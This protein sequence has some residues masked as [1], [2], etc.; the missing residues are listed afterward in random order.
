MPMRPTTGNT[1][2]RTIAVLVLVAIVSATPGLVLAQDMHT[3]TGFITDPTG[4]PSAG[5]QVVLVDSKTAQEFKSPPTD[6]TGLYSLAVP[7]GT[8]YTIVRVEAPDGTAMSVQELPPA[9]ALTAGVTTLSVRFRQR[10]DSPAAAPP[11]AGAAAPTAAEA[12]PWWK[13]PAFLVGIITGVGVLAAI[14]LS[15]EDDEPAA[16]PSSP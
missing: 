10:V 11:P 6:A 16:S 13:K 14:G 9:D 8:R 4:K 15:D 5:F 2:R 7:A 1:F 12:T 3:F